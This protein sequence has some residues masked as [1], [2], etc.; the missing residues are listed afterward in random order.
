MQSNQ[1]TTN[2]PNNLPN[3]TEV[4]QQD[5]C[6]CQDDR[7]EHLYQVDGT[8]DIPTEHSTDDEDTEP[9]NVHKRQRKIDAP[10]DT[11]RKDMTKQRQA[12]LLKTQ[13]E[14]ERAKAQAL[15]NRDKIDRNNKTRTHKSTAQPEDNTDT[16]DDTNNPRTQKSKGKASHP[17][18][19]KNSKKGKRTPRPHNVARVPNDPPLDLD[20]QDEDILITD[21]Y[22]PKMM[23]NTQQVQMK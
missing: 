21:E 17:D 16:I 9:D 18:Q 14:K 22:I 8:M 7:E 1:L 15:E 3:S 4:G 2:I 19:V 13:Q 20:T 5:D 23:A 6:D 11:I 10:A 12:Q